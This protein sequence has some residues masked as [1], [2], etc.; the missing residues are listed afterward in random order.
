MDVILAALAE[1]MEP[2]RLVML[3]VGVCT[4]LVIGVIPGLGGLFGMALLIPLSFGLDPYSAIALLL[5][6]SAVTTTS[7]TI[8]AVLIGVPGT[9]GS[10]ATVVDG[11]ALARRNEAGRALGAAY[12]ASLLGGLFG[13]FV[14]AVSLPLLKPLLLMLRTPDFL[15]ITLLGLSLVALL[16]GRDPLKGL[17]AAGIGIILSF[18]GVDDQTA[19]H[20]WTFG[21][22]YLWEGL[23]L[24]AVFLGLFGI[25][26]VASILSR[27]AIAERGA[28][29]GGVGE[30]IRNTLREWRLVLQCSG[31]GA[32]L[33]ALPGVG[34]SVVSWIAYGFAR[35]KRG[36]GPEFGQGNIRGVIGPESANNANEGGSL[37]PTIALGI[38]GG[39]GTALL[40]GALIVHGVVPGP[41]MLESNAPVTVAMIFSLAVANVVGA[42]LCLALSNPLSR[43]TMVGSHI[44]APIALVFVILGAF[45]SSASVNDLVVLAGFG[46]VGMVMKA[47][48]W[49]RPA[50]ALGF[51]LGEL[52]ERN[53]F[54]SW[55]IFGWSTFLRPSFLFVAM[56]LAVQIGWYLAGRR[57]R[58]PSSAPSKARDIWSPASVFAIASFILLTGMSLPAEA[59]LFPSITAT[60][61]LVIAASMVVR[62]L[63][64]AGN[65]GV[66]YD[67]AGP[68]ADPLITPTRAAMV[69]GI[70]VFVGG[71]FLVGPLATSGL[72]VA[73]MMR[74]GGESL[75]RSA[76]TGAAVA[77]IV[78]LV[79]DRLIST[80]WP[81]SLLEAAGS[82]F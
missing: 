56:L 45:Q 55:Q 17:A 67:G 16:V 4:G 12:S 82:A 29:A 23:P 30:G 14:L 32:L 13:A 59:A 72:I 27:T 63:L 68:P 40:L 28:V 66:A 42:G 39:A 44:I 78:H 3:L 49:P 19:A 11:H 80:P 71:L 79:F 18:V 43:I 10:M 31:I 61:L 26:E 20:R 51:V 54:L 34:L 77:L 22:I 38:P 81:R 48:D 33:G 50:L 64:P 62:G 25:P 52:V 7:D 58:G 76:A 69:M 8:P 15:A 46:V 70:P 6:M 57:K 36:D 37:I 53:F 60:F 2:L 74:W 1:M 65:T 21:Q 47:R 35:R 5:G 41:H 9:V 24:G 73:G 75:V